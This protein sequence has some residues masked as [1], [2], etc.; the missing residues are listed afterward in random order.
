MRVRF[1]PSPTG[2][3]HLGGLRT[4][5][6]NYA[7]VRRHGGGAVLRIEDTDQ[8]RRCWAAVRVPPAGRGAP[9]CCRS[10]ALDRLAPPLMRSPRPPH[11]G[12]GPFTA[13]PPAAR[14]S[15]CP[16][17]PSRPASSPL[18]FPWGDRR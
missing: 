1:A 2:G 10:S 5:L 15:C 4:A 9:C 7:L 11:D 14:R 3:L 13:Q 8:A 6:F 18:P 12:H 17:C 16:P